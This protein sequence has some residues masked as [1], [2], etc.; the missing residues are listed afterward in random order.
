MGSVTDNFNKGRCRIENGIF[1]AN[2]EYIEILS[3]RGVY[4]CANSGK[5]KY[6][7]RQDKAAWFDLTELHRAR[8]GDLSV[9]CGGGSYEGEGFVALT[10]GED[11][12]WILHLEDSEEFTAVT[13]SNGVITATANVYPH[14]HV[15]QLTARN[16]RDFTFTASVQPPTPDA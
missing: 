8:E 3:T 2:D 16:P 4:L 11:L 15:L 12:L 9:V 6:L 13:I 10:Q 7:M 14:H 1:F 5:V